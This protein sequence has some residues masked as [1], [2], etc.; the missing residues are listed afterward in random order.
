MGDL[1]GTTLNGRY[2]LGDALG[3][4]GMGAVYE[5]EDL[6]NSGARVAVKVLD[7]RFALDGRVAPRFAREARALQKMASPWVV[8]IFDAGTAGE[9]PFLVMERLEGEDLGER[10]KREGRLAEKDALPILADVLRGLVDAHAAGVV[11]RDLKPDNVFLQVQT[12]AGPV[13]GPASRPSSPSSPT[14]SEA[15]SRA[16]AKIVDFGISKLDR[17]KD[18]TIP[19][20]L[21]GRGTVVGTPYYI[22][23]EQ[24]RAQRDVDGRADVYSAGA[25]LFECL[26]GRPPHVG[27]TYEQV[28]LAHCMKDAVDV[29][30]VASEVTPG[31]A[32]LVQ[33]ALARDREARFGSALEMLEALV[34]LMPALRPLLE[35]AREPTTAAPVSEDPAR[36]ESVPDD[37]RRA[38][39]DALEAAS[40][41]PEA[42]P[43]PASGASPLAPAGDSRRLF[44]YAGIAL[45]TGSVLAWLVI[46][47]L[48]R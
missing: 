26:A 2:R 31:V 11:H 14:A 27:S 29:R 5:A 32:A 39:A 30:S 35:G 4:G 19:L 17:P 6:T 45:S 34:E 43:V 1:A 20:S 24:A 40:V 7:S 37:E 15:P 44:V 16:H 10:L 46:R 21:T 3:R 13:S 12:G 47:Y 38:S 23:P 36:G 25:I 8:R 42:T 22:S 48:G 33:K 9:R 41:A 28:I 18:G